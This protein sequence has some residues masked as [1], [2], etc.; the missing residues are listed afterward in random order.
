MNNRTSDGVSPGGQNHVDGNG[1]F[2][3][4]YDSPE[5]MDKDAN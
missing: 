4:R 1:S 2:C 3:E 5:Q